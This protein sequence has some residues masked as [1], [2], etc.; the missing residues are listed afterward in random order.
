M[1]KNFIEMPAFLK[2]LTAMGF[3]VLAWVVAGT[4]QNGI[5][6]YGLHMSTRDWWASGAGVFCLLIGLVMSGSAVL[7][8]RRSRYA[9]PIY[10]L[11]WIGI[12]TS[13][14]FVTHVTNSAPEMPAFVSN[15]VLT[16]LIALYLNWSR[17]VRDYFRAAIH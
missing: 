8:L 6:V 7:M 13:V 10:I 1:I 16:L 5:S 12:S 15:M 17:P 9:R 2:M 4:F 14:L 11:G 3:G